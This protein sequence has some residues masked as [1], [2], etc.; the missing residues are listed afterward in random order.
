MHHIG[1]I[2]YGCGNI[3]SV[4]QAF[5]YLGHDV[6]IIR[7][8]SDSLEPYSHLV[9]PGVGAF[10]K[11]SQSIERL[12]LGKLIRAKIKDGKPVLGICLGMQMLLDE[13]V[14][15]GRH[16]GLG[17]I[18]GTV[19]HLNEVMPEAKT[20]NTGWDKVHFSK[21]SPFYEG[22]ELIEHFYFNHAYV[23]IPDDEEIHCAYVPG[24]NWP[25]AII[26]GNVW[27]IQCHPEKSQKG[28]LNFLRQ[29]LRG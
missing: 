12:K 15:F 29:F 23:C 18:K 27:G 10:S 11:A 21:N 7:N 13:G 22:K 4:A 1:I 6:G 8:T 14:E 9:L 20:P 17:I 24:S 26:K 5:E 2:D 3:R 25:A 19:R 28:G 16:P